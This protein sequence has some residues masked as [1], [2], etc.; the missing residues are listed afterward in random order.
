MRRTTQS[1]STG[2]RFSPCTTSPVPVR[3]LDG[4]YSL[5]RASAASPGR[6]AIEV[7]L[8]LPGRPERTPRGLWV[9]RWTV[10][11]YTVTP[12]MSDGS[13]GPPLNLRGLFEQFVHETG[14]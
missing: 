3:A 11:A 12:V 10:R 13:S 5:R 4:N 7:L 8:A 2:G 6:R 1:P 9:G 14:R